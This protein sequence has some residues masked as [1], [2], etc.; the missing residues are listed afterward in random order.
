MQRAHA[1]PCRNGR[2]EHTFA[3]LLASAKRLVEGD[4]AIAAGGW[5]TDTLFGAG[6]SELAG[7]TLGIVGLGEIGK[8]VARR[9]AAFG[10]RLVYADELHAPEL[11]QRYG[12]T[13]IGLDELLRTADVVTLHVP[14]TAGT[15]KLI[16]ERELALMRPGAVLLNT[17]R[18]A[19]V[20]LDALAATLHRGEIRAGLDVVDPEPPPRDHPILSAPNVVRSP[21]IGGVTAESVRRVLDD[22]FANLRRLE[23]GQPLLN[24]VNGVGP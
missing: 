19:V 17:S 18:G 5:P 6:L 20:D 22:A 10:M 11:E 15:T 24:V 3:L 16:G 1:R 2:R 9:G 7:K 14:L 8:E 12:M 21:H 23:H 13:R 4:V